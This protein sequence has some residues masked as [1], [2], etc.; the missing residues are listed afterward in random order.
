[1]TQKEKLVEM[2]KAAGQEVIDR[3]EDLVG[4]CDLLNNI[5][6]WLRFSNTA[7]PEIEVTRNYMSRKGYDLLMKDFSSPRDTY[8]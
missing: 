7:A 4:E 2:V 8:L 6:I 1:M 5:D 3:A